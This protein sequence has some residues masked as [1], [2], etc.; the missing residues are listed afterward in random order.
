MNRFST[1]FGVDANEWENGIVPLHPV[2]ILCNETIQNIPNT[3]GNTLAKP[4]GTHVSG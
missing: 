3:G 1:N 2:H 4:C